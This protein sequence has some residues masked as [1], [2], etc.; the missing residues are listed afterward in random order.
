MQALCFPLSPDVQVAELF[1]LD[2]VAG[3]LDC[4][5]AGLTAGGDRLT[6]RQASCNS[7]L[8]ENIARPYGRQDRYQDLSA[9]AAMS[10]RKNAPSK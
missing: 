5:R 1:R 6:R 8:A 7:R 3:I 10:R 2:R 9:F 4:R